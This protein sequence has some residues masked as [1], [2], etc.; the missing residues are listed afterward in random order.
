MSLTA[1]SEIH[2][3]KFFKGIRF[4]L[5]FVY[6]SLFGLFICIFAYLVSSRFI[7]E[8]NVDFDSALLNYAIDLSGQAELYHAGIRGIDIPE[9]DYIKHFPFAVGRTYFLLRSKDGK[10]LT[11]SQRDIPVDI[12]YHQEFLTQ[13]KY[14]HSFVS[15]NGE[16]E[17][18]RAVNLKII[19]EDQQEMILQVATPDSMLEEQSYRFILINILTIPF[20]L[21]ISSIT[22]F[23]LAGRA[24]NPIR[25]ITQAV[26]NI[27]AK[28]LS[29]RVP[30]PDTGD[31][32]EKLSYT[33]NTLLDRLERSFQAQANFVANA[34]HQL[35]TPL[36]IIKG[37][38]DV[39][40]SKARTLDEHDKFRRSVREEVERL[41]ELVRNMLLISRV[42]AGH[43][44]FDF[45]PVRI[46]EVLLAVISRLNTRAREKKITLRFNIAENLTESDEVD[47]LG[48]R[49]LLECLFENLV[50]NA[51]KY[52]PELGTV[53]TE[54][55][56][57]PL[58]LEVWVSDQ[59]AGIQEAEREQLLSH[60]FK[61]GSP[62]I[63]GT[64]I[65]L[66]IAMQIADYH[67]AGISYERLQPQ[68]SLFKVQ[69]AK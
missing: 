48:E 38:L 13:E 52:S 53:S 66:P 2:P 59:G 14:T 10:L 30:V 28:N 57:G 62:M 26:N 5:T 44:N 37:E 6:A 63:P 15:L 69:F 67:R 24:L 25:N 7:E 60:R 3:G 43:E 27:A 8:I 9:K 55:R 46:D 49:Q 47:V 68:G 51:I 29:L 65:G 35:N 50:D 40:E 36:A 56:S 23:I 42:E 21:I 64:G 12:P 41:I 45:H 31:E 18:Y 1:Q 17:S 58:G 4:R 34:S 11:K 54:I 19:G 16:E 39:F 20:I 61:R 32:I 22:S 33:F